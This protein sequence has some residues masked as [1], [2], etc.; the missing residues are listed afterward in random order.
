MRISY[1]IP[2]IS[3]S[4]DLLEQTDIALAAVDSAVSN[5]CA[6]LHSHA[7]THQDHDPGL[8]AAHKVFIGSCSADV[9][10]QT[11]QLG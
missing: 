9:L 5:I 1:L 4:Q 7:R 3:L 2:R 8:H 10:S 11:G 6:I